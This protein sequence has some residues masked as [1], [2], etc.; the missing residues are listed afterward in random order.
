MIQKIFKQF[1]NYLFNFK[2]SAPINIT[3]HF[4]GIILKHTLKKIIIPIFSFLNLSTTF[5]FVLFCLVTGQFNKVKAQETGTIKGKLL[6]LNNFPIFEKIKIYLCVVQY[7]VYGTGIFLPSISEPIDSVETFENGKF[8]FT[9]PSN[10]SDYYYNLDN[11]IVFTTNKGQ[12]H[13]DIYKNSD[14]DK[15]EPFTTS[16]E[17]YYP[18][19]EFCTYSFIARD[20]IQDTIILNID[21]SVE[22]DFPVKKQIQSTQLDVKLFNDYIQIQNLQINNSSFVGIYNTKGQLI[23]KNQFN[24]K[25]LITINLEKFTKGLYL[26]K[27]SG[28]DQSLNKSFI[29]K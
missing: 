12:L 14:G 9:V 20:L 6:D 2:I 19:P 3:S 26:I 24:P 15:Y 18:N 16:F 21:P 13:Q 17:A 23:F 25:G 11:D 22:S 8:L 29:V 4:K 7:P 1:N 5:I 27:I 28:S 10:N